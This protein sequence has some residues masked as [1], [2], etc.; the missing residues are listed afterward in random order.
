MEEARRTFKAI[1]QPPSVVIVTAALASTVAE[2]GR[3]AEASALLDDAKSMAAGIMNGPL[4]VE[5]LQSEASIALAGARY[6]RTI[7][8][9]SAL[10]NEA[11]ANE[12][13]IACRCELMYGIALARSGWA[14][15]GYQ[16][17]LRALECS[18]VL[19]PALH[20]QAALATAEAALAS[21]DVE[22]ALKR[23]A[24]CRSSLETSRNAEAMWRAL[25]I[26]AQASG[27]GAKSEY[28][29]QARMQL[30]ALRSEWGENAYAAYQ[31][32]RDV[33]KLMRSVAA[34]Q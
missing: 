33:A 4:R 3:S 12:P 20:A 30:S 6:D 14:G 16:R 24:D 34:I 10:R 2:L 28:A 13:E 26:A 29:R 31:E 8:L 7:R 32:R 1:S 9:I 25:A 21:G 15:N 18:S 5:L 22:E 27:G 19:S 17:C 23:V 11:L